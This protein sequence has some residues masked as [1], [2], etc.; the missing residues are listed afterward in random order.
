MAT[1][2]TNS[3]RQ[4]TDLVDRLMADLAELKLG[5]MA[6]ALRAQLDQGPDAAQTKL[7]FL[8]A[9]VEPQLRGVRER[10]IDRR[11]RA[12]RF[13]AARTLGG[14]D[15]DFNP[16][17]DRELILQL[18]TLDFVRHGRHVLCAGMPGTGK[19]HIAIA[20]GH[21]ACAAGY[22]VR[23]TTSAA[24]LDALY[25]SLATGTLALALKPFVNVDLLIIDEVGIDRPNHDHQRD[26]SPFYK[27]ID[28]RSQR[29]A[30]T[31]VT[32]NID[33]EDWGDYLGDALATGAILDRLVGQGYAV[34]FKGES[35]RA[36]R[37]R[38]LNEALRGGTSNRHAAADDDA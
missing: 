3:R 6:D 22:R 34:S 37:H 2:K 12:A 13:P 18:A 26:S 25:A 27:V 33:W 10:R 7:E 29:P 32:T 11:L 31:V 20:L 30:S 21:E 1:K 17:I 9:L 8:A 15:W 28:T 38:E 4:P 35:Y 23:Y 5:E 24:M 36:A 16:D 19:S 14:F